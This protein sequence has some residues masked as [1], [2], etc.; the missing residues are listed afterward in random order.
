MKSDSYLYRDTPKQRSD[1]IDGID[2]SIKAKNKMSAALNMSAPGAHNLQ[3]LTTLQVRVES[4][5]WARVSTSRIYL[6]IR[7][8]CPPLPR[9]SFASLPREQPGGRAGARERESPEA[10]EPQKG[11]SSDYGV[12]TLQCCQHCLGKNM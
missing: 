9:E 8:T 11:Q 4:R 10:A 12:T 7:R 1:L 6:E 2:N 3:S 5:D